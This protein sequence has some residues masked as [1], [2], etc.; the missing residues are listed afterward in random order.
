MRNRKMGR[1]VGALLCSGAILAIPTTR[2]GAAGLGAPDTAS[3][4]GSIV[5]QSGNNIWVASPNGSQQ[6]MVTRDGRAGAGYAYPSQADNGTIE[7][8]RG[9]TTL[10]HLSRSGKTIGRPLKVA[11]GPNNNFS[12]H[13]LA[14]DP[15]ISPNGQIVAASI[16]EYQGLYDPTTG[17]KATG[18]ISQDASYWYTGSGKKWTTTHLAGTYL[19]AP[20]WIDNNQF[21]LF[22]PY[23]IAASQVYVL[24]R[25]TQGWSWFADGDLFS[26]E[27]LN[28]GELTRQRTKLAAIR[29][30]NLV[31]DWRSTSIQIYSV[32]SLH[33]D[34]SAVCSIKAQHGA[35]G[36]VTWSPD[37]TTL[38][39]SDS[40]GVWVSPVQIGS[41]NCGL[42]PRLVIRGGSNPDW[43]PAR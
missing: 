35:F 18:L 22:A 32:T 2:A 24:S 39:W 10:Y 36:K 19:M 21:L 38:A 33:S 15:A 17:G 1:L 23:N 43:G 28:R 29:G 9:W 14:M 37:G 31:N 3:T 13:T 8:V 11:S 30:P 42:S 20:S 6:R 5:Y 4:A 7:A 25:K 40:N 34:P 12:L 26:R 27:A 16:V 41:S